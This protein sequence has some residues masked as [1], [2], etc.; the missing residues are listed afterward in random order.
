MLYN[1]SLSQSYTQQFV[2]P[3]PPDPTQHTLVALVFSVICEP[4]SSFFFFF[5]F[6][7]FSLLSFLEKKILK[8]CSSLEV[9]FHVIS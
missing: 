5:F 6:A 1:T 8:Y 3:L 4:A 7:V 2:P 9:K